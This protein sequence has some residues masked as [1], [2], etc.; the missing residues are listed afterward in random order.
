MVR[1]ASFAP[2]GVA[3]PGSVTGH[4]TQWV[5]L[6]GSRGVGGSGAAHAPTLAGIDT[7]WLNWQAWAAGSTYHSAT[8]TCWQ[9]CVGVPQVDVQ[10]SWY[11]A[12]GCAVQLVCCKWMCSAVGMLQVD[13]Q[14]SR[15]AASGCAHDLVCCKRM[16]T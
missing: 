2:A 13:A 9:H 16:R 4:P 8:P 1:S 14:L 10:C 11:A 7:T 3:T 6:R 12:S 15:Y 5:L